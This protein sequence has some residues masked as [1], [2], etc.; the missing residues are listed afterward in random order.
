MQELQ[1]D[2]EFRDFVVHLALARA[3]VP[4]GT[5]ASDALRFILDDPRC[6]LAVF[7]GVNV[8]GTSHTKDN[9]FIIEQAPIDPCGAALAL[10][11]VN[12]SFKATFDFLQK[13]AR[14]A[15]CGCATTC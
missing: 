12:S 15:T 10:A 9:S 14:S 6:S 8:I 2:G 3:T 7:C 5:K 4:K 13:C 11:C 1:K